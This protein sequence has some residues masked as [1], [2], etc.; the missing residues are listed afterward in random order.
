[1]DDSFVCRICG[2]THQGLVTDYAYELPDVV[3]A[4]PENE[5]KDRAKFAPDLCML[6]QPFFIRCVLEIPFIDRAERFGWG[7]WAEVDRKS[8]Q[9]HLELY[10]TDGSAEPLHQGRIANA[11]P[12][13]EDGLDT[14]IG[15]NSRAARSG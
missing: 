7:C 9:R 10:E 1:M 11:L 14:P 12:G 2:Q 8:F 4:I 5:R 13:D 15:F 6:D 3:W